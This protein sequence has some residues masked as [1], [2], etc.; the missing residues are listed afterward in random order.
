MESCNPESFKQGSYKPGKYMPGSCKCN[1][2]CLVIGIALSVI[3]GIIIGI[4]FYLGLVPLITT[5]IWIAFGVA[6]L[7]L[8]FLLSSVLFTARVKV[9]KC[10][11]LS[12]GA[13]LIGI[14][15]TILT[16]VGALSIT[17]VTGSILIAIL[18]GLGALFFGLVLAAL[19]CIILC[20]LDCC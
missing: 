14:L 16:A 9:F 2:T 18:I 5:G 15:G 3:F 11:C 8:V 10:L 17:L 20:I 13:L 12:L 1:C 6:V 19:T 7:A 4:I